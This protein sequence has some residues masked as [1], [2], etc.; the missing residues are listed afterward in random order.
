MRR[1]PPHHFGPARAST[2]QGKTP[3]SALAAPSHHSNAP[4]KHKS[5]SFLSKKIAHP[6]DPYRRFES[7]LLRQQVSD[8]GSENTSC[9][10]VRGLPR[11][12]GRTCGSWTLRERIRCDFRDQSKSFLR[13][14]LCQCPSLPI[15]ASLKDISALD[16][17]FIFP[18]PSAPALTAGD[19]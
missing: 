11:V 9:E 10:I 12:N 14:R 18:S 16:V 7:P 17:G 15:I 4:I 2:R 5:Q 1:H 8:I 13:M 19:S 3:K 6:E